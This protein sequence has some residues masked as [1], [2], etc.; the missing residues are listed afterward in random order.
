MFNLDDETIAELDQAAKA[1]GKENLSYGEIIEELMKQKMKEM[2][3]T[4]TAS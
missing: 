4:D 3:G 1:M 2:E